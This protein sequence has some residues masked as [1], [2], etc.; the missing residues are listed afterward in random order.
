M[1]KLKPPSREWLG[2]CTR[3]WSDSAASV[4]S[5]LCLSG[6]LATMLLHSPPRGLSATNQGRLSSGASASISQSPVSSSLFLV[7]S[8]RR[9]YIQPR[10]FMLL[11][12]L[13]KCWAYSRFVPLPQ[14]STTNFF[15]VIQS[16]AFCCSSTKWIATHMKIQLLMSWLKF[17][18]FSLHL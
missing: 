13:P 14:P 18:I 5:L 7:L 4:S 16:V 11:F 17:S 12:Q 1:N 3:G 10:L 9:S 2:S 8:T 15:Y 6:P